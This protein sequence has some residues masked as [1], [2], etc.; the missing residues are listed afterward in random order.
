MSA[1][2]QLRKLLTEDFPDQSE[3]IG[4]LIQPLN[5]HMEKVVRSFDKSLTMEENMSAQI[6]DVSVSGVYPVK[7]AWSLKRRPRTVIV[8]NVRRTDGTSFVLTNA[9]QVQWQF[10]QQGELQID[11]VVGVTPTASTKYT[12][13]IEVKTS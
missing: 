13:T 7:I 6:I 5:D 3:W 2:P 10:N 1:V 11:T 8:G 12:I 4:K 9:V